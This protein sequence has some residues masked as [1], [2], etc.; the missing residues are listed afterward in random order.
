M[1]FIT[2]SFVARKLINMH[3]ADEEPWQE[4]HGSE[5]ASKGAHDSE[6]CDARG[7]ADVWP[8]NHDRGRQQWWSRNHGS[9]QPV[10]HCAGTGEVHKVDG[11]QPQGQGHRGVR[12]EKGPWALDASV[13]IPFWAR[14]WWCRRLW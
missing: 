1:S 10:V 6:T 3:G 5:A 4:N 7:D 14:D 11:A 13:G 12:L 9:M 2:R 8:E